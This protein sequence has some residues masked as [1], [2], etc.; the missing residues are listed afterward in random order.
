MNKKNQILFDGMS[1]DD[2]EISFEFTTGSPIQFLLVEEKTGL[3]AF[4]G[5]STQP[6]P[7][8]MKSPGEFL[9]GIA[10]DFTAIFWS[11]VVPAFGD[12]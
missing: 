1:T 8:T 11:Y 9:Q 4:P 5:L 3:P 7:G 6:E 12:E 10:T 2:M